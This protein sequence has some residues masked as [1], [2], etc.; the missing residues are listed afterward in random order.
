MPKKSKESGEAYRKKSS[1]F[2]GTHKG[3]SNTLLP[4]D[5]L[6]ADAWGYG[7]YEATEYLNAL[8][9]ASELTVWSDYYGVC[10]FFVGRCLTAYT[11]D[12]TQIQPDYYVLT[13]RGEARYMSRFD[14]WERLSGLTAHRYYRQTAIPP[15]WSLELDDRPGN[16]VKVFRVQLN[17]DLWWNYFH[18]T[19]LR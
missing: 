3:Q 19:Q 4:K 16:Y 15:V 1:T 14:R 8:P 17:K 10:E 11:F 7:G 2:P 13:R 18:K 5:A 6:I 12:G 9:N